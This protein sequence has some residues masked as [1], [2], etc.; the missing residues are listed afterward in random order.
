MILY[1]KSYV[2]SLIIHLILYSWAN[3]DQLPYRRALDILPD[4]YQKQLTNTAQ[5]MFRTQ[6]SYTSFN[7][8]D[9]V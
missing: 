8:D 3:N 7:N 6:A 1:S 5:H 2:C 9:V 4:V